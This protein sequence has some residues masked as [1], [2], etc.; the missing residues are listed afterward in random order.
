MPCCCM[1][2]R[3][4]L[5]LASSCVG[6]NNAGAALAL[7]TL[8]YLGAAHSMLMLQRFN[9]RLYLRRCEQAVA[10][11]A[12]MLLKPFGPYVPI[13]QLLA[14]AGGPYA[15]AWRLQ[16]WRPEPQTGRWLARCAR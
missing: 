11:A 3:G 14:C 10:M 4:H 16:E 8:G 2:R 6:N 12:T 7:G 13:G 15:W 5:L 1:V 9:C